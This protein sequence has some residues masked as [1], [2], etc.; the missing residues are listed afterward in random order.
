MA[1]KRHRTRPTLYEEAKLWDKGYRHIAGIDEVG[2]GAWAGPVVAAAVVLN[3]HQSNL[4]HDREGDLA[5]LNIR[6]SKQLRPESRKQIAKEL[7]DIVLDYA[8][9]E[10]SHDVVNE[11]GIVYATQAAMLNAVEGLNI[12][13]DYHLIDYFKIKG[14][15]ENKQMPIKSG[16]RASLSIAAASI[17]AKVH[18]DKIMAKE[19]HNEYPEYSF[20]KHKGYG[21]KL[22]QEA[23]L[24][25]GICKLHR[26]SFVPDHILMMPVE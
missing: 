8:I 16:D 6:D 13:P 14:L 5:G 21:T 19:Y 26:V 17:I 12:N 25:Y 10:A 11:R 22:H 1:L 23:I 24:K 4:L 18:R 3:P 20:D 2:R 9:G 15:P 7:K